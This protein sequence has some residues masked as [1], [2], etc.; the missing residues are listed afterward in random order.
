MNAAHI[1]EKLPERR[2]SVSLH[3]RSTT[4]NRGLNNLHIYTRKTTSTRAQH[5]YIRD[6]F[7]AKNVPSS[8][9]AR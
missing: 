7:R 9:R 6:D 5:T 1:L 3:Y 4:L 2:D 8:M